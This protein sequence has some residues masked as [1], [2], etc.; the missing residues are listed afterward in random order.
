MTIPKIIH[1]TYKTHKLP[2]HWLKSPLEW[3]R[4]HPTWEYRFWT[5]E[6]LRNLVKSHYPTWLKLYDSYPYPI[7]RVDAARYM[8]LD[9]YGG[10]YSDLDL[11]PS[12]PIDAL[13]GTQD[14]AYFVP[15]KH[16]PSCFTNAFMASVPK[17][18]IW[19][20]V[21]AKLKDPP[22][23]W[24]VTKHFYIMGTTGPIFLD[25]IIKNCLT[26]TIGVLPNA[27]FAHL[28][29]SSWCSLDTNI[30]MFINT[31]KYF[32]LTL[33]IGMVLFLIIFL[34]YFKVSYFRNKK[35]LAMCRSQRS[36]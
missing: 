6:D 16:V 35:L 2:K 21:L 22:P 17:A 5:D 3:K 27:T 30:V 31:N 14:E 10:V 32:C 8:I 36:N 29:G 11:Y 33:G 15:S 12:K 1:Q 13:V 26:D 24:G 28:Q 9:T 18:K 4:L 20:L 34:I 19:K 7:Q 25:K 23:V